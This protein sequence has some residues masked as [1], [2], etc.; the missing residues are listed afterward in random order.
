MVD[1]YKMKSSVG[2]K[3]RNHYADVA[4]IQLI[5]KRN[6]GLI[7]DAGRRQVINGLYSDQLLKSLGD[8]I[9]Y[10]SGKV[11]H[12]GGSSKTYVLTKSAKM[13]NRILPPEFQDQ[14]L[15]IGGVRASALMLLPA[16]TASEKTPLRVSANEVT[17]PD[18]QKRY[19]LGFLS[20]LSRHTHVVPRMDRIH[21]DDAR[22]HVHVTFTGGKRIDNQTGAIVQAG[23]HSW[24]TK[25]ASGLLDHLKAVIEEEKLHRHLGNQWSVKFDDGLKLVTKKQFPVLRITGRDKHNILRSLP[26]PGKRAKIKGGAVQTC[27]AAYEIARNSGTLTPAQREEFLG[28]F[29]SDAGII[30]RN[31]KTRKAACSTWLAKQAK[32][33]EEQKK[34]GDKLKELKDD[35]D[36]S[37]DAREAFDASGYYPVIAEVVFA[38]VSPHAGK[39][40]SVVG[41]S[42]DARSPQI[43]ARNAKLGGEIASASTTAAGIA[44]FP[45]EDIADGLVLSLSVAA[46]LALLFAVTAPAAPFLTA[47]AAVGGAADAIWDYFQ[48]SAELDEDVRRSIEKHTREAPNLL[49]QIAS[50]TESIGLLLTAMKNEGCDRS[51]A[52]FLE[53]GNHGVT[54][55]DIAK[56]WRSRR[57]FDRSDFRP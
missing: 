18:T 29:G 28:C 15:F 34:L 17:L 1:F 10:G 44:L 30:L 25:G 50:N 47:A 42:L 14:R 53:H 13:P 55:E 22:F 11:R 24:R 56:D 3:A 54:R 49:A 31:E 33:V 27:Y 5:V 19:L 12:F 26:Y 2:T 36:A 32:L 45:V 6:G 7:R 23:E 57:Y 41:R 48:E 43:R 52:D 40:G 16:N 8:L 51:I 46:G 37:E 38:L 9:G 20:I 21:V 35:I 39:A 4:F